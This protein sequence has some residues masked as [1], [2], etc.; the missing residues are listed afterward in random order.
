[1]STSPVDPE[2]VRAAAEAYREL[3]PEY[4]DAVV[5]AFIDRVDRAVAA[6]VE[7]RL[8]AERAQRPE[9]AERRWQPAPRRSR[10]GLLKGVALG[11]CAG[12]LVAGVS[13][14]HVHGSVAHMARSAVPRPAPPAPQGPSTP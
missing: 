6:R 12:A 10:R 14:S 8:A 11:L 3:G 5:A 13:I 1:M 9:P 4:N 2:D 7:A